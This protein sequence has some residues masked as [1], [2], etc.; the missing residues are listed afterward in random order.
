MSIRGMKE[1]NKIGCRRRMKGKAGEIVIIRTG[2]K[3]P[4]WEQEKNG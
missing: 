3:R 4:I 1:E 2:N